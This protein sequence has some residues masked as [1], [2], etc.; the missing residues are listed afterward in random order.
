MF[1]SG[2]GTDPAKTARKKIH[3]GSGLVGDG[4]T[5]G[6]KCYA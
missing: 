5:N 6:S 1:Y 4:Y 2:I 3:G